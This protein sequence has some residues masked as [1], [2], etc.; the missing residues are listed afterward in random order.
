MTARWRTLPT[1]LRI[2]FHMHSWG[3]HDCLSHPEAMLVAARQP[4]VSERIAL[5]DH[6]R[7]DVALDDGRVATRRR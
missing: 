4:A 5:T 7:L 6:D 2:D 3:S 1:L